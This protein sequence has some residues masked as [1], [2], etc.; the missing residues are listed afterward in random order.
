MLNVFQNETTVRTAQA[1]VT[2]GQ[3]FVNLSV[4]ALPPGDYIVQVQGFQGDQ[5]LATD[6][7]RA[8]LLANTPT[9][10]TL[11]LTFIQPLVVTPSN[12][13]LTPGATQQLTVTRDGANVAATFVSNDP[14]IATVDTNGLV[15]GVVDGTT[16]IQVTSDGETVT[17]TVTVSATVVLNTITVTPAA[18]NLLVG[19]TVQFTA[20]GNFSDGST[21]NLTN[22]ATWSSSVPGFATINAATGLATAV[23]DGTTTISATPH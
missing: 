11:T 4:E 13:N 6:T 5:L 17:A 16:Q 12:F 22:T 23:A 8:T 3:N 15:T 14:G 21:Q 18:A 2:V 20:I 9:T 19:S 1:T 10:V 7:A